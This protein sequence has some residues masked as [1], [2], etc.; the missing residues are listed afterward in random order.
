MKKLGTE[1]IDLL[2]RVRRIEIKA[3]RLS[4]EVFA[5]SYQSA[6]R[7]RGMAFNQVRPYAVGDDIRDIDWN[8]TARYHKPFI[9]EFDEERELSVMLLVDMSGSLLFG[10][11]DETK[12]ELS[13]E[14]A[15]TLAFSA[16]QGNDKVGA[17]LF[18]D[19]VDKYIPPRSGRSHI[20]YIIRELLSF[21]PNSPRTNIAAPLMALRTVVKKQCTAFLISDFM[22]EPSSYEQSLGIVARKHDMVAIRVYDRHDTA[23]PSMGLV[24]M[25]DA[26][27]GVQRWIDSSSKGVKKGFEQY[28]HRIASERKTLLDKYHI[29]RMEVHTGEDYVPPMIQLFR[30]RK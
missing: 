20:L 2:R 12:R 14:I 23:L 9:K 19:K 13:T 18:S 27:T 5:G 4:R 28:H 11:I 7:G 21:E 26:E 8:V 6:F 15:A 25:R 17:I 24:L 30:R 29:D 16:M 3:K 10:T 22:A 1:A